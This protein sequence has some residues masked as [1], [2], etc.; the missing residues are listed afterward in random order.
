MSVAARSIT[1]SPR[2]E[3]AASRKAIEWPAVGPSV[4]ERSGWMVG[5]VQ[6]TFAMSVEPEFS[7]GPSSLT[8]C[9]SAFATQ[10]VSSVRFCFIV[11]ARPANVISTWQSAASAAASHS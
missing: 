9:A 8:P 1:S 7:S 6:L 2:G 4:I 10:R 5:T 3:A 11:V